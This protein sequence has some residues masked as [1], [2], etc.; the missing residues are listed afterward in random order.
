MEFVVVTSPVDTIFDI[1][2]AYHLEN[3]PL[4]YEQLV[5]LAFGQHP[6]LT[7]VEQD[8]TDQGLVNG[9]FCCCFSGIS[10]AL[11]FPHGLANQC[12][13]HHNSNR[14]DDSEPSFKCSSKCSFHLASTWF[15]L[16]PRSWLDT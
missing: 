4:K 8:W 2:A 7:A 1:R 9:E 12:Q 11:L 10:A 16:V 3:L 15:L 13:L 6:H 5:L 14:L